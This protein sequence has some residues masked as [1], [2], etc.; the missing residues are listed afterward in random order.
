VGARQRRADEGDGAFERA[1]RRRRLLSSRLGGHRGPGD[2]G[3]EDSEGDSESAGDDRIG[4]QAAGGKHSRRG[5]D[6][7]KNGGG[8]G[9][10]TVARSQG[11]APADRI[12]SRHLPPFFVGI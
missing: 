2:I 10:N 9:G 4:H 3:E 6:H 5:K 7:G 1:R 12:R 8:G 11:A